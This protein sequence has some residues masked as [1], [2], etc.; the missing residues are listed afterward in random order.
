MIRDALMLAL[1]APLLACGQDDGPGDASLDGDHGGDVT[2]GTLEAA[3]DASLSDRSPPTYNIV[4][5]GGDDP[6]CYPMGYVQQACCNGQYCRGFCI[7][8]SD[9]SVS[10]S[11]YGIAGGCWSGSDC[12]SGAQGC[13]AWG[14]CEGLPPGP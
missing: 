10:C 9:G 13:L 14:V 2:D 6:M 8:E 7:G 11:C 5:G 3:P 12:C 4:D 1:V